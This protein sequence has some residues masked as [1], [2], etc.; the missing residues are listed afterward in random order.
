MCHVV[1]QCQYINA[2]MFWCYGGE[3]F[4]GRMSVLAHACT[5][6]TPPHQV[7]SKLVEKYRLALHLKWSRG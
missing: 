5:R 3:D 1:E 6:G 7:S 4:V 2:K